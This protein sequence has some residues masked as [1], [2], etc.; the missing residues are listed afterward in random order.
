V[1]GLGIA[2]PI[3]VIST[4]FVISDL[5]VI[6]TTQAPAATATKLTVQVIGHQWWWEIVT[7]ARRP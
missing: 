1:L 4:L 2:T 5:F 7:R 6:K 3:I